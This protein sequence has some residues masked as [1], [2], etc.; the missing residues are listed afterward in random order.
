MK[1]LTDLVDGEMIL[2]YQLVPEE[3]DALVSVKSDEDIRHMFEE[4]D[5]CETA[6]GPRL[7]AFLFPAKPVVVENGSTETYQITE[8]IH[9]GYF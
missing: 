6:G 4:C 5:R 3:L 9:P 7:R 1:R 8:A 2:K